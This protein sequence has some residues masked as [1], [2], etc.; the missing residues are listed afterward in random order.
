MKFEYIL[1]FLII[2][3]T[4]IALISN[5]NIYIIFSLLALVLIIRIIIWWYNEEVEELHK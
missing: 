3:F 4:I 2:V 5:E 1:W